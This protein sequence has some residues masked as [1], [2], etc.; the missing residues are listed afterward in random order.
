[1]GTRAIS[2]API[3][4]DLRLGRL[5]AADIARRVAREVEPVGKLFS[6]LLARGEN[7]LVQHFLLRA[8]RSAIAAGGDARLTGATLARYRAATVAGRFGIFSPMVDPTAE[9]AGM[10]ATAEADSWDHPLPESPEPDDSQPIMLYVPGGGFILPP[11]PTQVALAFRLA[12]ACGCDAVIGRHRLAPEH[13][14]PAAINDLADRYGKLLDA[15]VLPSRILFAGDSAGAT[16][17]LS[18]L[19]ELRARKAP[20]PAG[21]ML[22][23]PWA[24]LAMRGWSYIAKSMSSDSPFRME[25]AAFCANLY[26]GDTLPT[27]P[28]ASPAY[29]DLRGLPPLIIHCSR[30]DMHFDDAVTLSEKAHATGVEVR[31]NYWDSPRHHLERFRSRDAEKSIALA[32]EAARDLFDAALR[33]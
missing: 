33:R 10:R 16:L 21:A 27:D 3:D 4:V 18:V 2:T 11:S 24:D 5:A 17:V 31:M 14:F 15:G 28:R 23:S 19:I 22:F 12:E 25:T 9:A 1:M 6:D 13:P 30:Y 32:G 8:V 20:M 26:L 7:R 29:A